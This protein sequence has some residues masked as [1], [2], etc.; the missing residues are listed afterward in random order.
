MRNH[1]DPDDVGPAD[2]PEPAPTSGADP[3]EPSR[4]AAEPA[5]PTEPE[6]SAPDAT[7]PQTPGAPAPRPAGPPP[8]PPPPQAATGDGFFGAMRRIGVV[9]T[10]DRW[11][12]G[13][14]AGLAQR[15]GLDPLLVR[16]IFAAT[17]LVAGFGLVV[18]GLAWALLPE[19]RDGRIHLQETMAGRFDS[20]VLGALGMVL[21][22]LIRGDSWLWRVPE[23]VQGLAWAFLAVVVTV[24]VVVVITKS[25]NPVPPA[26]GLP[27]G[28][29]PVPPRPHPTASYPMAGH[30]T[31][32]AT[33]PPGPAPTAYAPQW[34]PPPAPVVTPRR[35]GPGP[36]AVGV[37]VALTLIATAGL[38]L[39]DRSGALDA[40]VALVAAGV[41]VVLAGLG[42]VV[43]GLRGRRSGVLGFFAIVTVLFAG[44][45]AV[46]EA[47]DWP[48]HRGQSVVTLDDVHSAR[49]GVTQGVG[50]VVVDLRNISLPGV[51]ATPEPEQ[52]PEADADTVPPDAPEVSE[53]A[54]PPSRSQ[55]VRVPV[56]VGVGNVQIL[57]PEGV[58]TRVEVEVGSGR[59]EWQIDD[60]QTL[61]GFGLK[62]TFRTNRDVEGP[63]LVVHVSI[64]VGDLT[65]SHQGDDPKPTSQKGGL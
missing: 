60:P 10:D 16:G 28:P 19:A 49:A 46:Y 43:S 36:T 18:Y 62:R 50:D 21:L 51:T 41:C 3:A 9:R 27:G 2:A 52:T 54:P 63:Q 64:G 5:E 12:G 1:T 13:V 58:N 7:A 24:V 15:F 25:S 34:T 6:A 48:H 61:R 40:P 14:C 32:Q 53:P 39:A 35:L 4:A 33:P 37:V 23:V 11:I 45:W 56:E 38:L 47:G 8:G 26:P 17:V 22:G 44:P 42:I 65:I 59:V 30:P 55:T 29:T 20:A 57:L 31:Y